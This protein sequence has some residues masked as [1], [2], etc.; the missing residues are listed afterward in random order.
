[1]LKVIFKGS[2]NKSTLEKTSGFRHTAG[3]REKK[4]SPHF[5]R[6]HVI[7]AIILRDVKIGLSV[8][9]KSMWNVQ[10]LTKV[11]GTAER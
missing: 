1:M 11:S 3:A 8:P 9:K 5:N 6:V 2:S 4:K 10:L 7:T